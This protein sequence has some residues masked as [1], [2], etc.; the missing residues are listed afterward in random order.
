M[1]DNNK[2]KITIGIPSYK[3]P[4]YLLRAI[5][6]LESQTYKNF[7]TLVSVNGS[8][9]ENYEYKKLNFNYNSNIN[10]IFQNKNIGSLDNHF[11]LLEKCQTKYFMWL[12]D[13]DLLSPTCLENL[14]NLLENNNDAVTAVPN[15]ELV[16]ENNN[17]K[18]L[19]PSHFHQDN[20]L[21]RII[22]YCDISDDAFFHGLHKTI[23]LKKCTFSGF[24]R[25]NSNLITN[26]AYIYLFDLI[27]QG[28]IVFN[29]NTNAKWTNH[30]YGLK[31]Y[32]KNNNSK[33]I[34]FLENIIKRFNI[35]FIYLSKIIKW[36][37]IHYLPI[38]IPILLY[39][40]IRDLI[41]NNILIGQKI[42]KKINFK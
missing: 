10:L 12:A 28:K 23:N 30:D 37:K 17:K 26:W 38:I 24:W 22:N 25:P 1:T 20:T 9:Y 40:F 3:R 41:L 4:N 42:Y 35:N 31:H 18:I 21:I 7:I 27:I 6:S 29:K 5:K 2:L 39:F 14:L 13:D 16:N 15:W 8:E 36:K 11:Y 32:K 34:R 19:T 33:I